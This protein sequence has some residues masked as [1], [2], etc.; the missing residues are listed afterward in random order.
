MRVIREGR[1]RTRLESPEPFPT[2]PLRG[3]TSLRYS[4]RART[5]VFVAVTQSPDGRYGDVEQTVPIEDCLPGGFRPFP[6]P[7]DEIRIRDTLPFREESVDFFP[8]LELLRGRSIIDD[9][10]RVSPPGEILT[11]PGKIA[12]I[13]NGR[14]RHR[15]SRRLARTD[16]PA[17]VN[18][19]RQ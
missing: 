17:K 10:H 6:D 8:V 14:S 11:V 3:A 15:R 16:V 9:R 4:N 2:G 18:G 19:R 12:K 1:E 13:G 5:S 7:S